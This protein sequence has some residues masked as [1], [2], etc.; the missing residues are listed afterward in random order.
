MGTRIYNFNQTFLSELNT[1][2]KAY[3]LGLL[4]SDGCVSKSKDWESYN[5]NFG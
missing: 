4:Y 5:I 2:E 3:F 1:P